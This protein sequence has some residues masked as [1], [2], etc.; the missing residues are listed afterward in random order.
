VQEL[1][2]ARDRWWEATEVREAGQEGALL[3]PADVVRRLR[4]VAPDDTLLI[5]DA[6]NPGVW[7]Y[8]WEIRQQGT[9]IKPVG[10]GNMGFAV[11]AAI[12]AATVDAR[13]PVLV[14]VGDGS[15]GMSLGELETLGR[16]GGCV[17][18][19]VLNDAGYGNIRQEQIVHF[20]G[21]T[22]GVDFGLS[23]FG[24]VAQGLGLAGERVTSLDALAEKVGKALT[25]SSPVVLDVPIDPEV[26]AWT[27]PA[28]RPYEPEEG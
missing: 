26:N 24:L 9:Y 2:D 14:L 21:R 25:G 19:V 8:L 10:F 13:R 20:G 12:A 3:S 6:G 16:V 1:R 28:F 11:P 22:V 15:L 4:D 18:V 23:D 5:P 7:S 27:F 17:C